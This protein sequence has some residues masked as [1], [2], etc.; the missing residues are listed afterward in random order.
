MPRKRRFVL[1][2]AALVPVLLL[3]VAR[4]FGRLDV[5]GGDRRF[6]GF[7]RAPSDGSLGTGSR[8]WADYST[9]GPYWG[10]SL[11]VIAVVAVV[12]GAAVYLGCGGLR[13]RGGGLSMF[14][15]GWGATALGLT[16]GEA[17][18][19]ETLFGGDR[20]WFAYAPLSG[21]A[22]A[23][24]GASTSYVSGAALGWV[25]GLVVLAVYLRTRPPENA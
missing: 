21:D 14:V 15:L 25:V 8:R 5:G 22:G 13:A 12:A 4:L 2:G 20:G 9:G 3:V 7:L 18:L 1:T 6:T 17:L 19:R 10:E 16:A 24:L 11:L 23:G